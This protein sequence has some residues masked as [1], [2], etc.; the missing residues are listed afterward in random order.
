MLAQTNVTQYMQISSVRPKVDDDQDGGDD[1]KGDDD[2]GDYDNE[3]VSLT[4]MMAVMMEM[5][6]IMWIVMH[7]LWCTGR[8][9]SFYWVHFLLRSPTDGRFDDDD[10]DGGDDDDDD[11]YDELLMMMV[12]NFG[13]KL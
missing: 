6:K 3:H 8:A 12:V 7:I 1:D 5:K 2:K 9:Q 4:V 13:S 10:D 11:D